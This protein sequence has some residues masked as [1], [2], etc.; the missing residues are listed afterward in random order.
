MT[1]DR[2]IACLEQKEAEGLPYGQNVFALATGKKTKSTQIKRQPPPVF[3][4][5]FTSDRW[6]AQHIRRRGSWNI[7]MAAVSLAHHD[8]P[9]L[10]PLEIPVDL[11]PFASRIDGWKG[12]S[13]P[14]LR[15]LYLL[16]CSRSC[17][18]WLSP[19]VL[20]I[21]SKIRTVETIWML[22]NKIRAIET[23]LQ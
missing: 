3:S 8:F 14:S 10:L 15:L 22:E 13:L 17:I 19:S 5:C 7:I 12:F 1:P 2:E 6:S 4:S 18:S 9:C 23:V 20:Y 16:G 11:F 21:K